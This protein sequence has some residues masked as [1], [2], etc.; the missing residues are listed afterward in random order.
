MIGAIH[1]KLMLGLGSC[2]IL[3]MQMTQMDDL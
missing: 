1:L 2:S 3:F